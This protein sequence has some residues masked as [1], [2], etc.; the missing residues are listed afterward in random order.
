MVEKISAPELLLSIACPS[1]G[2]IDPTPM[3]DPATFEDIALF[4]CESDSCQ[5]RFVHGQR[6]P[7]VTVGPCKGP[8]GYLWARIRVFDPD[9]RAE[10]LAIEI[11]PQFADLLADN[12][13][14]VTRIA[15]GAR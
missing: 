15:R 13:K 11:D 2:A 4:R 12:L 1:C 6:I 14:I 5:A 7:R 10:M 9:T 8:R 3:V